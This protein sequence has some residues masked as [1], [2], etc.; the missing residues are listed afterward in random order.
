MKIVFIGMDCRYSLR[1]LEALE[2]KFNIVAVVCAAPRNA[3]KDTP[4]LYRNVLYRNAKKKEI[5]FYY[6]KNISSNDMEKAIQDLNCDLICVASCSQL[7]KKNIIDL[8]KLGIMN[9]HGAML[10]YYKGPNPDYWVFYYQEKQGAVTIHYIDEGED[11]GDIIHQ[12]AFEIPF[13]MTK[14]EYQAEIL[15]RSP[16]LMQ[17]SVQEI[18][19]GNGIRIQQQKINTFRARNLSPEDKMIDF[20]NW[21]VKHAYHFLRGTDLLDKHYRKTFWHISIY[22]Y[23]EDISGLGF[24]KNVVFCKSG[25]GT[26]QET[27]QYQKIGQNYSWKR[28]KNFM[29]EY[30][31]RG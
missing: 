20:R 12:E 19:S 1:H 7:L 2:E 3:P 22:G 5:P 27:L 14:A 18:E 17:Q 31:R 4:C 26:L 21:E 8:P 16:K 30:G 23:T 15:K 6:T 29:L 25:G 13:G 24:N 10:P 11:S 28:L 9:A